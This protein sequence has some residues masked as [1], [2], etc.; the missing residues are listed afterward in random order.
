MPESQ[1]LIDTFDMAHTQIPTSAVLR[2]G[3][4]WHKPLRG[5]IGL[6]QIKFQRFFW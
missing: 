4:K 5:W 2:D 3:V 1:G 6:D